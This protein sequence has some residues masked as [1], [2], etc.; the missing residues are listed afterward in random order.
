M[1]GTKVTKDVKFTKIF[2][3]FGRNWRHAWKYKVTPKVNF[4]PEKDTPGFYED[5]VI[6]GIQTAIEV[7]LLTEDQKDKIEKE[8]GVRPD[9]RVIR[10]HRRFKAATI[11]RES[12]PTLFAELNCI[13]YKGLTE[14]EEFQLMFDSSG[15]EPLDDYEIY[16]GIKKLY[17]GSA[18]S[19]EAIGVRTGTSRNFVQDRIYIAECPPAV[20]AEYLKRFTPLPDGSMPVKGKDYVFFPFSKLDKLHQAWNADKEAKI[21]ADSP[22]SQFRK[23]WEEII[24][25]TEGGGKAGTAKKALTKVVMDSR[26][27]IVSGCEPLEE[28]H[29]FYNGEGG[30]LSKAADEYKA[31]FNTATRVPALE[32]EI[33]ALKSQVNDLLLLLQEKNDEIA[34][35]TEQLV[36]PDAVEAVN[37][38]TV[39]S[40]S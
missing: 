11:A 2:A 3:D 12:D 23:L 32:S 21:P 37:G 34:L 40:N 6:N 13:V 36:S 26:S 33:N 1:P 14:K 10:G 20:E 25:K 7:A 38:E 5:I 24:T 4:N 30:D 9:Y 22:A 19:Q 15:I 16:R 35:L 8:F 27:G 39:N 28:A 17:Y 31:V 18:L 29:R